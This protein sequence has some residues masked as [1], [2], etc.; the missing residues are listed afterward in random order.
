MQEEGA[1]TASWTPLLCLVTREQRV[2]GQQSL[3]G[4]LAR[5]RRPEAGGVG[6]EASAP[7]RARLDQPA[8]RGVRVAGRGGAEPPVSA[9]GTRLPSLCR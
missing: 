7:G 5:S 1:G 6:S 2:G 9:E 3:G 4:D 8:G